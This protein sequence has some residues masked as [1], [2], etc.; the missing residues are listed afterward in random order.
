MKHPCLL[1]NTQG[2]D[3]SE[4]RLDVQMPQIVDVQ[5]GLIKTAFLLSETKNLKINKWKSGEQNEWS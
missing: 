1:K 3:Y 4:K 5:C 2:H